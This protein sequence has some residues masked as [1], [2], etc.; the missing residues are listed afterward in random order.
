VKQA[1]LEGAVAL[2]GTHDVWSR[3]EEEALYRGYGLPYPLSLT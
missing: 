1:L 2:E 3:I